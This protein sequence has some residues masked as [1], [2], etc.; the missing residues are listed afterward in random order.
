MSK[1]TRQLTVVGPSRT[2]AAASAVGVPALIVDAGE[3]ATRGFPE[4]FAATICNKNTRVAYL[5]A[6]DRFFTWRE[7]HRIGELADIEPLR[8][9]AYI[10]A[11]ENNFEK[12]IVKQHLAAIRMLL[13]PRLTLPQPYPLT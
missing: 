8:V 7:R 3:H 12:P 11:L 5:H 2:V 4:F 1:Q 10:E 13:S 9:A 6:V